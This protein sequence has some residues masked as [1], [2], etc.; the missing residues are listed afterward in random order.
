MR[1]LQPGAA[2]LTVTIGASSISFDV[3]EV[4][5]CCED[6]LLARLSLCSQPCEVSEVRSGSGVRHLT[7]IDPRN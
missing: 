1:V 4:C 6:R 7:A 5:E 2:P 3:C